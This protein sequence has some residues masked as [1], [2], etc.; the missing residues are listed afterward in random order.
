[1]ALGEDVVGISDKDTGDASTFEELV[2]EVDQ[3]VG[4]LAS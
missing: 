4:T 1:M 3:L 2:V